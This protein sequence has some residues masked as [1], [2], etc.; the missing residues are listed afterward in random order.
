MMNALLS[1]SKFVDAVTNQIGKWVYRLVLVTVL[2]S[3][4]NAVIRK[5][6]RYSSNGFLE[7]QWYLFAAIFLLGAGYTLLR[8]E[9]VRVDVIT[10]RLSARKQAWIDVFGTIF[11]LFPM[12]VLIAWLSWP[13]FVES[14]RLGEISANT[15]GLIIWPA[16]LLIP[17]GFFLLGMQGLSELIKRI[18]YLRGLI[19]DPRGEQEYNG[20]QTGSVSDGNNSNNKVLE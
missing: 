9:H 16:R 17:V 8:N 1:L 11:F 15:G 3:A 14:F 2:I 18:A 13:Q 20:D 10:S 12:V 4:A 7:V 6:F 19:P 5:V